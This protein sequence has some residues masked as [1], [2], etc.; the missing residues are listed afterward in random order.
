MI[1]DDEAET[2][3]KVDSKKK[4]WFSSMFQSIAGKENLE[5]ADLEPALKALKDRL[6]TKNVKL[7]SYK[8]TLLGHRLKRLLRNLRVCSNQPGGEKACFFYINSAGEL[9]NSVLFCNFGYFMATMKDALVRILTPRRSVDILRNVHVSKEQ[10]KPY[11][12]VFVGVNRVGKSI[13]LAKV[14][15]WLQQHDINVMMAACD[16]FRSG[17]VEQLHTHARMLQVCN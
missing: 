17:A 16:T 13:N 12:V 8:S 11:V 7:M 1:D 14:A 10:R 2:D 4:G 3:K 6:M 15:Y 9:V 5:K